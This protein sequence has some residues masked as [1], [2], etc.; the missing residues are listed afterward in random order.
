[1]RHQHLDPLLIITDLGMARFSEIPKDEPSTSAYIIQHPE[2]PDEPAYKVDVLQPAPV[3]LL[4]T[5]TTNTSTTHTPAA[6]FAPTPRSEPMPATRIISVSEVTSM[7]LKSLVQSASDFLGKPILGAVISVPSFFTQ[8]QKNAL[9]KAAEDAGVHVLQLVNEAGAVACATTSQLWS[10]SGDLPP[11][12]TQLIVDLGVSS[13]S[14]AL[15]SLREGLVHI[16]ASS[17][18]TDINGSQID[19]KLI[20]FFAKDFTKK[21]KTPLTVCPAIHPV[22]KRAEAKLRLAVEHTKRTLSASPGAAT[23]SVESLRDGIDYTGAINRMRFDMEVRPIYAAVSSKVH[24]LLAA[25]D[26]DPQYVDEIIYVGGS[27]CLP[28]LDEHLC[29]NGGFSESVK[30]PFSMGTVAGGGVGDPTEIIARGCAL[31]AELLYSLRDEDELVKRAFD[32]GSEWSRVPVSGRTIGL[33]PGRSAPNEGVV[34]LGETWIPILLKDTPLP[35]RRV[36]VFDVALSEDSKRI[37]VELW[38]GT[39]GVKVEKLVLEKATRSDEEEGEEGEG[40]EEEEEEEVKTKI[41]TDG[42]YLG[43]VQLEAKAGVKMK[44]KWK[45]KVQVRVVCGQDGRIHVVVQEVGTGG[46]VGELIIS[47]TT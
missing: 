4:S 5:T 36:I 2:F 27:T 23:C 16:L 11:D 26:V 43:H 22:D 21:T 35:A 29:L 24:E 19:D 44:G 32:E 20:K 40:E 39:E 41:V 38:E 37:A 15:L 10:S 8:D 25:A 30:T 47:G 6:S 46:S 18:H 28:G 34:D 1:V 14:L 45:T 17:S 7:F 13:L 31:Q 3:P 33:V 9:M 12:R 42:K